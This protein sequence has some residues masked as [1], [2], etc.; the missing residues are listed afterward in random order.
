MVYIYLLSE[1]FLGPLVL[2]HNLSLLLWGEI[3]LDVEIISDLRNG[4]AL[5]NGGDLGARELKERLD[6]HEVGGGDQFEKDLLLEVDEIGKVLIDNIAQVAASQWLI[7]LWWSILVDILAVLDDLLQD[8]LLHG[9]QWDIIVDLVVLN[10]TLHEDGLAGD[11]LVDFDGL[12]V[13][14]D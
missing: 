4:H 6:V 9:W 5:D 3:I 1:R 14:G 2:V 13:H 11:L 10:N 12:A 8:W 7:D